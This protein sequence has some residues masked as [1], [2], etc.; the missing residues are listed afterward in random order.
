MFSI[1]DIEFSVMLENRKIVI[2]QM[3]GEIVWWILCT[4]RAPGER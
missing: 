1:I 3:N 4:L 2:Y